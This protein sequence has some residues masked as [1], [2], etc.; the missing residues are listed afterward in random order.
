MAASSRALVIGGSLGGLFTA[1][2]LLQRGW[3]VEVF[4]HSGEDLVGRGAG[5]IPHPELFEALTR[6]GIPLDDS[7][8]VDIPERVTFDR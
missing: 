6:I 2:L 5:I 4:E 7:F 3:E 1:N 8:G